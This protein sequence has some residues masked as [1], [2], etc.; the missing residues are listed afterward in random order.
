MLR[1]IDYANVQEVPEDT[2]E[3]TESASDNIVNNT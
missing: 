2:H 3:F 1:N